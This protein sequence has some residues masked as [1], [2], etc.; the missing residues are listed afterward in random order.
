MWDIQMTTKVVKW[1]ESLPEADRAITD[2]MLAKL[3]TEGVNLKMPHSRTLKG[4]LFELRY[5]LRNGKINQRLTY[6]FRP[7]S[8]AIILTQFRKTRNNE[9]NQIRIARN[10]LKKLKEADND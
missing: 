1:Y 5:T 9:A 8:K 6:C 10:L 3:R 7:E 4:G 2:R